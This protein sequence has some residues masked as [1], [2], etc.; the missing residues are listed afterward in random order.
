M[1]DAAESGKR[2]NLDCDVALVVHEHVV[3]LRSSKNITART[4]DPEGDVPVSCI[5]F[6]FKKLG[7]YFIAVPR[8]IGNFSVEV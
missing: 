3:D 2:V 1:T 5:Q 8:L 6:I 4:V 7:C